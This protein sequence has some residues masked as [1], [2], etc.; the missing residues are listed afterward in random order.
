MSDRI[1]MASTLVMLM[2]EEAA[3]NVFRYLNESEIELISRQLSATKPL[4]DEDAEKSAEELLRV[5]SS[6]RPGSEGGAGYAKRIIQ[7]TLEPG[8]AKRIIDRLAEHGVSSGGVFGTIDKLPAERTLQVLL[9]EHPQTIAVVLAQLTPTGAATL[10]GSLPEELRVDVAARMARMDVVSPDA[11]RA[12]SDVLSERLKALPSYT[13]AGQAQ[14]GARAVAEV[15]NRLDKK[16]SRLVLEQMTNIKPEVAESIRQLMFI[17]E[18]IATLDAAA[19]RAILQ[20]VDKKVLAQALKGAS[21]QVQQA[22][23]R[24]MS[25]RAVEMMNE[26]L[27]VMGVLKQKDINAARSAVIEVVRKLEQDGVITIG[28]GE[29]A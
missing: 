2:G 22:F 12:I 5:M 17:F 21:D 24:N 1:K 27:E 4:A 19:V 8:S 16:T 13:S 20:H 10:L 29:E 11:I 25:Q 3:S 7:R 15:F 26:E 18:D 6:G 23:F 28:A 14:G 9:S